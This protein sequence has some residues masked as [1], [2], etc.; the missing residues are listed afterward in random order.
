MFF[1]TSG[2]G[3][4]SSLFKIIIR[5]ASVSFIQLLIYP[6]ASQDFRIL[7]I[8]GSIRLPFHIRDHSMRVEDERR[9]ALARFR[10]GRILSSWK[11]QWEDSTHKSVKT[12]YFTL[13]FMKPSGFR[14]PVP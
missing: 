12:F 13:T 14:S 3:Y 4:R 5:Y 8:Q 9:Q 10:R 6:L 7:R 11:E 2:P 1:I